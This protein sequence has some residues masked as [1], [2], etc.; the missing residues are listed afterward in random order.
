MTGHHR[1]NRA[2]NSVT[3]PALETMRCPDHCQG[4]SSRRMDEQ[5]SEGRLSYGRLPGWSD[6]S[7][8][9]TVITALHAL[10]AEYDVVEAHRVGYARAHGHSH[11]SQDIDEHGEIDGA[12]CIG[13]DRQPSVPD[14]GFIQ[15]T[16]SL[17]L[18]DR[19]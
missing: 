6:R 13:R 7:R 1:Q 11:V 8:F 4:S 19:M 17:Q 9:H 18:G 2:H 15:S 16:R 12:R 3:G 14:K 10:L 5:S